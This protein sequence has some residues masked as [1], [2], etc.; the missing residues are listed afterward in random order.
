[1]PKL[2]LQILLV[3]FP[4]QLASSLARADNYANQFEVRHI[5]ADDGLPGNTIH[6]IVQ[7]RDG[8]LWMAGTGGLARY[9]GYRFVQFYSPGLIGTP[10]IVE[11]FGRL[12]LSPSGDQLWAST[13]TFNQRCYDLGMGR[14]V[15]YTGHGDLD[16]PYRRENYLKSGLW[17][18]SN[19][20]GVRHVS[21]TATGYVT[22]DYTQENGALPDDYAHSLDEDG[23]GNVWVATDKGLVRIDRQGKPRTVIRGETFL[24]CYAYGD[25]IMTF[26]KKDQIG[27]AHV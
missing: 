24:G 14:F 20:E 18:W 1:M 10:G 2:L 5:T 15:D 26:S 13:A 12:L 17:M 4:V 21:K 22:R 27:R 19:T 16:R 23:E 8:F 3:L 25:K 11:H 7:D 9:D 6:D